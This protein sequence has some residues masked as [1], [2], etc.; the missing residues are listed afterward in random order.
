MTTYVL[1]TDAVIDLLK[2]VR[3]TIGFVESLKNDGGSLATCAVVVAEV[4]SGMSPRDLP[5]AEPFLDS[6]V[7]LDTSRAAA[8]QAGMWRYAFAREGLVLSISD[9]LVAATAAAHGAV[10]VTGNT[11]H[12]TMQ[13]IQLLTLPRGSTS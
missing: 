6:L 3:S 7:Y 13:G 9:V 12:Y 10:L 1:D 2:G 4:F 8:L 11:T 5:L